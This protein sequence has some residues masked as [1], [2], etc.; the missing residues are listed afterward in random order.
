MPAA[1]R[2]RRRKRTYEFWTDQ[3]AGKAVNRKKFL[4]TDERTPKF[5]EFVVKTSASVSGVLHIGRL[6]DTIR[7]EAVARSLLDAGVRAKLIW[8]AEDMDPMRKI[9]DG[10]PASYAEYIGAPVTDIPDPWG[11]HKSYAEH[12][13]S[14]YFETLDDF[15]G[16]KMAKFS[17]RE[18][19]KRGKFNP[20]IRKLMRSVE[21][22]VNIQN[23]YRRTKLSADAW[24]PWTPICGNCGKIITT[25]VTDFAAR[26]VQYKCMDYA[27]EKH[28]AKGCGHEG[29]N[30]PLKGEGKLMWKG[31][32][33]A[34]W[35]RWKVAS[36]GAGKEYQVPGSAFWVN[37]EI[38][39]RV[40]GFP[41]PVPIFYE[42]LIIDGQKMSASIGNVVYPAD[43]LKRAPAEALRLLFLKDP[44]RTRDFKWEI[45]PALFDELDDLER[46]YYGKKKLRDERDAYNAKRLFEIASLKKP[47][48]A[49]VPKVAFST[50]AELA[51]TAPRQKRVE[52]LLKKVKELG[53]VREVTPQL[54]KH[55]AERLAF[56]DAAAPAQTVQPQKQRLSDSDKDIVRKLIA[57]IERESDAEKLQS[58]IFDIARSSGMKLPDF[59]RIVYRVLFGTDRGPRLGQYIVDA[60]RKEIIGKMKA[61]LEN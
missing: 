19:Y 59:F 51:K 6:S 7:G 45:L 56:V 16:L 30:D 50:L 13:V 46:V 10:V 21:E 3:I 4:Y 55:I 61:A 41:A 26:K 54:R 5:K 23:K 49:Y 29:E 20:Y 53:L 36:E 9:P 33:A 24:N 48:K 39:E 60:G 40:L 28:T 27:F 22:L 57:A 44:M 37:A 34:Q 15:V 43:W 14:K 58:E 32:W 11:C 38:C 47:A 25:R 31:E 35:A 1:K 2:T 17:M 52:F 8:V 18:E 12:H 42:H